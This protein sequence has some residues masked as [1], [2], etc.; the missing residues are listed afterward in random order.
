ML[1]LRDMGILERPLTSPR[2][3]MARA[4]ALQ[5]KRCVAGAAPV[6]ALAEVDLH[7]VLHVGEPE[8]LTVALAA[9]PDGIQAPRLAIDRFLHP[10]GRWLLQARPKT[11]YGH[12]KV[13]VGCHQAASVGADSD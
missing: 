4:A 12:R 7:V 11:A 3:H 13:S 8:A 6:V 5:F 1:G 10:V 2:S 9:V